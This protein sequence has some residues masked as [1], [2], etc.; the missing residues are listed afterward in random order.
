MANNARELDLLQ[1]IVER[2]GVALTEL[3][4]CYRGRLMR[5]LTR[6]IP[7]Q[8]MQEVINDTM[9]IVWS[10]AA[11]FRGKSLLSTWIL[12]I[13]YRKAKKALYRGASSLPSD[14]EDLSVEPDP[15]IPNEDRQ[16]LACALQELSPE[17]RN[18][19]ELCYVM[20]YS[21]EET[22]TMMQCPV[23]TV[24]TRMFHARAKLRQSL[25]RLARPRGA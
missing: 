21:C 4:R 13:A 25:P 5:F 14:T 11:D 18:T 20:G 1:R 16:W 17:Q 3:H 22:A 23:N 7:Q 10:K 15:Q 19:L 9:L 24:K 12:G 8:D 6:I 2:D